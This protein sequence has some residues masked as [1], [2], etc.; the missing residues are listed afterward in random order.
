M[1]NVMNNLGFDQENVGSKKQPV[2]KDKLESNKM[3]T[4]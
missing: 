1:H 4:T 3:K 2:N